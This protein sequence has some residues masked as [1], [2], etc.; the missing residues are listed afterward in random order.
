[1]IG[2]IF[3]VIMLLCFAAAW[4]ANILKAYRART[5]VGTSLP[6]MLIIEVGYVCGM[7]NKVVNDEV[8]ID[9]VFNYVLAFYILDFCL[10][11]IG[12]ILYFRNRAIV[13]AGRADAE[14]DH[15][16]ADLLHVMFLSQCLRFHSFSVNGMADN[17]TVRL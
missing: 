5:A 7:L 12:V 16:I 14:Y 13:R 11:L 17:L 3:E 9:G 8:F 4:P 15:F 2:G 1:M 6:F 10:V